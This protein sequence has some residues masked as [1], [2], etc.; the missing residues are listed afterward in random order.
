MLVANS[1]VDYRILVTVG[2]VGSGCLGN[3]LE[4]S[5]LKCFRVKL[6]ERKNIIS[7][8]TKLAFLVVSPVYK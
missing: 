8:W 3:H 2:I 7:E 5:Y 6:A 4:I 1:F